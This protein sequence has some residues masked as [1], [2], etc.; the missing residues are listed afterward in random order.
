MQSDL[1]GA[2]HEHTGIFA[3]SGGC[4]GREGDGMKILLIIQLGV[5][6][7]LAA[8]LIDKLWPLKFEV[9]HRLRIRVSTKRWR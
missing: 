5:G 6:A 3:Q 2:S 7:Y 9:R 4:A 1:F 8:S